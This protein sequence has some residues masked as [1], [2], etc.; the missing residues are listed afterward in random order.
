METKHI[1]RSAVIALAL[2]AASQGALAKGSSPAVSSIEGTYRTSIQPYFCNTGEP[3]P[4]PPFKSTLS[5]GR[6]GILHEAP[7]NALFAPGQRVPGLGYW[8]RT[9][10]TDYR[11]VFE[12]F[13]TFTAGNYVRGVQRIDQYIVQEDA[14]HWQS[15]ALVTFFDENGTIV[16]EPRCMRATGERLK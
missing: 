15:D 12:A 5:F 10:P 2:A 7:S 9:G 14:D 16:G 1:I 8:E 11:S 13:I 3:V 4:V 6:G